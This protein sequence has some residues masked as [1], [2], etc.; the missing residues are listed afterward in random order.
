MDLSDFTIFEISL[1]ASSIFEGEEFPVTV[2]IVNKGEEDIDPGDLTI[3]LKGINIDAP[4]NP[5]EFSGINKSLDN[6]RLI[7]KVSEY[8][9]A[10]GEEII[11]FGDAKLKTPILG[12]FRDVTIIGED[13]DM[14]QKG[15]RISCPWPF[16][17]VTG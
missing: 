17:M 14:A 11:Q 6:K 9:E 2:T 15:Q 3:K 12:T 5:G 10:G 13:N 16:L 8:N 4:G 1:G 7:E